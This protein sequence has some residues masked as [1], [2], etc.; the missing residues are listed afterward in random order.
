MKRSP[1]VL[2]LVA[3]AAGSACTDAPKPEKA[4]DLIA[5]ESKAKES[6]KDGLDAIPSGP[7]AVVN[8]TE[9]SNEAFRSIYD[10]KVKKYEDRGRDIPVSADRRYR[11]TIADRL[12]YQEVLRQEAAKQ[13]VE[14]DKEALAERL[15]AQK[16]GIRDWD[17]HLERRGETEESLRDMYITELREKAILEKEGKLE[18]TDAEVA[19]EYEKIKGSYKSDK[20]RLRASHVLIPIG[21]DDRLRRPQTE[22]D[23]P[24]A[25]QMAQWEK[26]AKAKADEVYAKAKAPDADFAELAHEYS[27][28]PS[29]GKG[30]DLGIFT[31]DRMVDEFSAAAFKLKPGQISKPVKTKFGYHV[32]KVTGKWGPGELPREALEDQITARLSMRKLHQ[33]RR[34][35]RE[36][37]LE[38]YKITNNIEPTLGP[39]PRARARGKAKELKLGG[40]RPHGAGA[41]HDAHG[42]KEAK[43]QDAAGA[44]KDDAKP[45]S[46]AGEQEKPAGAAKAKGDGPKS[47]AAGQ[48][49][50]E[51]EAKPN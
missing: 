44:G 1:I 26:E 11:K 5:E 21:P 20:P 28:G 2:L 38:T 16:R 17:K 49:K 18:L 48:A 50:P 30:G 36:G 39:D 37:L 35:L 3:L 4:T 8:G 29:S 51:S 45:E 14:Y 24:S 34:D 7:V 46:A 23:K 31:E 32:I 40:A 27:T 25:E 15:E 22:E 33:G 41:E 43:P 47:A 9:I 19:E 10:R 6:K 42:S 12:I 13:G